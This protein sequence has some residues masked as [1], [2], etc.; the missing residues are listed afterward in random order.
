MNSST[1][2]KD[3]EEVT[4]AAGVVGLSTMASRVLGAVRDIVFASFFGAG[5]VSDAFITAFRLPN[6]LRRLFGEGSLSLAFIPVFTDC[7]IHQGPVEARRMAASILRL[8]AL[9][10]ALLSVLGVMMAPQIVRLLAPGFIQW[11]AKFALTAQLAGIMMPYI[12]FIGIVA[13][14]MGILNVYGHFSAPALAPALLNLSMIGAMLLAMVFKPGDTRQALWLAAAVVI[15][16][17]WQLGLQIPY[18]IR[19]KIHFWQGFGL[20][21]PQIKRVILILGPVLFGAAVYQINSVVQTLLAT[22]LSQ[23]SVSYLYYADR[24][25]QLP[26]GVFAIATATAVLPALSRQAAGNQW[27]A[28][29]QTFAHAI[30]SVFFISL[31]SMA[32][33]IVLR[34]PIVELLFQRGAFDASTTRLT[35]EAL[36]YYGMG[37]WSFAAVRIVLNFFF[38]LKDTR[39]PVLVAVLAVLA[40]L[41]CGLALMGPMGHSG[42]ALALSL[43]SIF[44]LILLV[45]ML[46]KKM[47]A[48]IWRQMAIS[49]G[50]SAICAA[51]MG[52]CVWALSQWLVPEAGRGG[53]PLLFAVTACILAGM[54]VFAAMAY[55]LRAPEFHDAM[56]VVLKRTSAN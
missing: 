47:G 19:F 43:A 27:D 38:A 24:L 18:L 17:G 10:L 15:G 55:M 50:R 14:C 28:L 49:I 8:M 46:R 20:W 40:N 33:L 4:R 9:V 31:P 34:V 37:L 22:M 7:L 41:L 56:A 45:G 36:L 32:G 44:H 48:L 54:I 52:G 16:G 42:L 39:T 51:V 23:G 12:F 3:K 21:H 53:I 11:P 1:I 35:A 25:V 6:V 26:L 29:R 13:L 2:S 5:M 30:Q